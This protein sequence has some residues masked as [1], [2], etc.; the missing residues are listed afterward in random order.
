MSLVRRVS[1]FALALLIVAVFVFASSLDFSSFDFRS[2]SP[3]STGPVK[4]SQTGTSPID[5]PSQTSA[6]PVVLQPLELFAICSG[7]RSVVTIDTCRASFDSSNGVLGLGEPVIFIPSR[8][9]TNESSE[10]DLN[11]SEVPVPL[12]E[13]DEAIAN[14][15]PNVQHSVRVR[16]KGGEWSQPFHFR[17]GLV[18][19]SIPS[20]ISICA[21]LICAPQILTAPRVRP[22]NAYYPIIVGVSGMAGDQNKYIWTE[23][24]LNQDLTNI[25]CMNCATAMN[26][27]VEYP[28]RLKFGQLELFYNWDLSDLEPGTHIIRARLRNSKF[29]GEWSEGV[30]F[31]VIRP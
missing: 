26:L 22:E 7:S 14:L 6:T 9:I 13:I 12:N 5:T 29:I 2:S 3:S 1:I 31:E 19:P 16:D 10:F 24:S 28:S 23:L 21:D 11:L 18:M 17:L 15:E 4:V 20:V 8:T 30:A 27:G 25:G